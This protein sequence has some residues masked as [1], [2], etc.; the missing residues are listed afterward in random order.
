V[1]RILERLRVKEFVVKRPSSRF[2]QSKEYIFRHALLQEV[3]YRLLPLTER[4]VLHARAAT[5]L[6]QAG[7]KDTFTL[8]RHYELAS[9]RERAAQLYA[10]S[11]RRAAQEY[12]RDAALLAI[13]RSKQ[14]TSDLFLRFEMLLLEESLYFWAGQREEERQT[15]ESLAELAA[16]L[17][18]K[19]QLQVMQREGRYAEM[20]GE[21]ARS[22]ER[23]R[24]AILLAQ[25]LGDTEQELA[26]LITLCGNLAHTGRYVEVQTSAERG[27]RLATLMGRPELE[28]GLQARLRLCNAR[29][30]LL[31][32]SF[33]YAEAALY[34]ARVAQDR[35]LE[36]T[37][38]A[39]LGSSCTVLGR[40]AEAEA[41]LGAAAL[42]SKQINN[43]VVLAFSRMH[44][45]YLLSMTGRFDEAMTSLEEASSLAQRTEHPGLP[46]RIR[47]YYA[48]LYLLRNAP[49]DAS[50]ACEE[51]SQVLGAV[52][53]KQSPATEKQL[54][55]LAYSCR[56]LSLLRLQRP[57]EAQEDLNAA[58]QLRQS[59]GALEEG[60]EELLYRRVL[61][62]KALH[63]EEQA[64][65]AL[66]EAHSFI[67]ERA[68]QL[69]KAAAYNSSLV[70]HL[71]I[72]LYAASQGDFSPTMR[73]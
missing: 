12:T 70:P 41:H 67:E 51:A 31:G 7:E 73:E 42:L 17:S 56:A 53:R 39:G 24:T 36:A 63:Q 21:Y 43:S 4:K 33:I 32:P 14:L 10:A 65:K 15:L 46:D 18:E 44:L 47:Y 3:A 60:E 50:L 71:I 5:W 59:V 6:L 45:G 23:S 2:A 64:T 19:E 40:Y 9:E 11:A 27:I 8:A 49:N 25:K 37:S 28:C 30:G 13:Q 35:H 69:E 29:R 54:A 20:T 58:L 55:A 48:Q 61:V 16:H 22:E 52:Q 66:A 62:L 68:A 57:Q 72:E 26:A 34:S 38:L 1:E